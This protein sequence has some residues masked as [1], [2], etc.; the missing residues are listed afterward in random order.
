M[1]NDSYYAFSGIMGLGYGYPYTMNYPNVLSLMVSQNKI[2][3]P[4]FSLGLG[5]EGD[6]VC[7]SL[8]RPFLMCVL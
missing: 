1:A 3:A 7:R 2:N 6:N 4:I 5:G 8:R